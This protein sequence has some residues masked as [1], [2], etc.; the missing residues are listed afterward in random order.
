MIASSR[1]VLAGVLI[2]HALVVVASRLGG[3]IAA[4]QWATLWTAWTRLLTDIALVVALGVCV[5]QLYYC[6]RCASIR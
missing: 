6:F 1:G 4:G 3:G 5:S 2:G